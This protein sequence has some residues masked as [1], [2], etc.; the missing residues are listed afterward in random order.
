MMTENAVVEVGRTSVRSWVGAGV[1]GGLKSTLLFGRLILIGIIWGLFSPLGAQAPLTTAEGFAVPQAGKTFSFPR[2]HGSHPE[3]K[4]EWW[5]VTGHLYAEAA[6]TRR[7]GFQ[8]TFFRQSSPDKATQLHLAHMAIIDVGTGK[9]L[10][11]ERLNRAGWDAVSAAETLDVRQGNWSLRLGEQAAAA[12][13]ERIELRGGV[14]AEAAWALTLVPEKPLV[15]FGE[16]GVSRKG[17]AATAASHYL[18]FS[19]LRAEGDVTLGEEKFKVRGEA[20]MDHEISSSQLDTNQVGW[21]WVSVQ[22]TDRR[23]L[24]LYRLRTRDGGADAASSLTWVDAAGKSL[25]QKFS[26]EV[27]DT[28][29]SA[30][31]GAVYP[32]RVALT[33]TDP[34]TGAAVRYTLEPLARDQELPGR[35][36]GIAYWE[37]ACRVRDAAGREV[38]SAYMELTGYA[39]EL[40]L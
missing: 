23:E 34:A 4:I 40:K 5:Y 30:A 9:F 39:A 37:G 15:V 31:T 35:L 21:D 26:W 1:G 32:S 14:R 8:A 33:T 38:G 6:G 18:T 20:W 16:D 27:L 29:K 11:Q 3:F 7:F 12:G 2:D 28:W 24:M 10:H 36:G 13:A 25:K 19:R 22:F 17:A